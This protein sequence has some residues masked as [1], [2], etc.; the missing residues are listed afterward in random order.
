MPYNGILCG[1]KGSA[2][3]TD[4][5]MLAEESVRQDLLGIMVWFS[6]VV[7]GFSYEESWDSS[8]SEDSM[9]AYV[10]ALQILQN[11]K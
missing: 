8:L 9:A 6:S 1:C 5:R 11:G 3:A 2:S 7:N 4:I 10:E